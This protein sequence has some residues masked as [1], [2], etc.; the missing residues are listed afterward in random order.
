M[1]AQVGQPTRGWAGPM[2][3]WSVWAGMTVA[4]VLFIRQYTRNM[5]ICDDFEL[6]PMMTGR[7]PVN[8]GW[9]WAQHNEHRPLISRLIQAGLSRF[10]SNDFRTAKYVNVGLLSCSA[11]TMMILARR[12]RVHPDHG[13]RDAPIATQPCTGGEPDYR[14]RDEPDP[15]ELD[16]LLPGGGCRERGR[17]SG[18]GTDGPRLRHSADPA[19]AQRRERAGHVAPSGGVDVRLCRLGL[20]FR[21]RARERGAGDRHRRPHGKFG[22]RGPLSQRLC[23]T[24][25]PPARPLGLGGGDHDAEMPEFG[26]APGAGRYWPIAGLVMVSLIAGTLWL[27]S[28]AGLRAPDERRRATGLAAVI[29][30]LIVMAAAVGVSRSGLH[31]LM[32]L[33]SRY[34]TIIAPLIGVLYIAWLVYGPPRVRKLIHAGLLAISCITLPTGTRAGLEYGHR[35][36]SAELRVEQAVKSRTLSPELMARLCPAI[37]PDPVGAY[38]C[39]EMLREA[40]MGPFANL[41]DRLAVVPEAFGVVR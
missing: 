37:H 39:L 8:L 19:A 13:L 20:V 40:R 24:G 22:R 15:D 26:H 9:A 10:V 4:A 33:S 31:P 14:L 29:L 18:R 28:A 23:T 1:N 38:S 16:L 3:A 34:V 25:L 21:S 2:I 32:G 12:L 27:L 36:R 11:A 17:S 6:V 41:G 35:A 30:A 5:P 7:Q